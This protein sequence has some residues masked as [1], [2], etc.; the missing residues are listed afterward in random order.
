MRR[1][2]VVAACVLGVAGAFAGGHALAVRGGA[3]CPLGPAADPVALDAQRARAMRPLAGDRAAPAAA[4]EVLASREAFRAEAEADGA[5]CDDENDG[6][7]V[8]CVLPAGDHEEERLA[9]VDRE[10]RLVAVDCVRYGLTSLEASRALEEL[11]VKARSSYGAP[12]RVWGE[13][14]AAF[15]DAPL[16]QA[17]FA[18]RFEDL[19]V[20]VTVTRLR[21]PARGGIVLRSQHRAVPAPPRGTEG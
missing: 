11:S 16:R 6:A 1:S 12:A 19:A 14:T 18:Y 7:V 2:V 21:G 13:P 3:R 9:R 8:R 5:R 15:L 17:G 20:D 10:G 4:R